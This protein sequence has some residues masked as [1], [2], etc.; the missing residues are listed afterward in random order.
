MRPTIPVE[1]PQERLLLD[2]LRELPAGRV[3]CNTVGRAQFAATYAREHSQSPVTCWF[4][5]LYQRQ[6]CEQAVHPPRQNLAFVCQADPPSAEVDLVAWSFSR[7]GESE[8]V[9]EMLQLGHERLAIGGRMIVAIDNPRDQWLHVGMRNLFTKVTRRLGELGTVYLATKTSPLKK[10]K[11]YAAEFAFRDGPQWI[12][13]RTRPGVFSHRRLDDGARSLI[14]SISL[15]PG[16]RALDLGCGSGAVALA[17]ALRA[18]SVRVDAVDSNPRA[19]ESTRW[20]FTHA[21]AEPHSCLP[22]SITLDCDGSSV[23]HDAFDLVLANPPYFSDFRI[24]RLFVDIAARALRRN[25]VLQLVTKTP[26]WYAD[27]LPDS[28]TELTTQPVGNYIV[29][30]AHKSRPTNH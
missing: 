7:Q 24:A 11:S 17:A 22:A 19:V 14:K 27:H 1:R 8:L 12:R 21:S 15:A 5:D 20:A 4:L 13:L 30:S 2:L 18:P 3:L 25:G 29:V 26:A 28:F 23:A 6:Q 9:R 10:H 16:T